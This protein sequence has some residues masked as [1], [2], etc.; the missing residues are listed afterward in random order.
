MRSYIDYYGDCGYYDLEGNPIER[1]KD[2]YPY[3]YDAFV[4]YK[5]NYDKTNKYNTV[6]SDRLYQWDYEKYNNYCMEIWGDR[7]QYFYNRTHGDIEKFL[8]LY[9]DK[10]IVLNVIMEGCN[11]ASGYPYWVFIFNYKE[12]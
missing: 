9:F 11:V 8:G 2:E 4:T 5:S 7:G 1:T 12:V 3:S 6:Y 10:E